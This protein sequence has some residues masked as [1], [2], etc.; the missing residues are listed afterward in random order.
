MNKEM[1]VREVADVLNVTPEAIKEWIRELYPDK[2]KNGVVTF[3]DEVEVTA[4]KLKMRPTTFV[5]GAKTDL[6]KKLIINQAMGFLQEEITTLQSQNLQ[7]QSTV[8]LLT[9]DTSKTFTAGE[10]AKEIG[11][12]SA[13]AL[14]LKLHEH[15]IIYKHN[16]T[17]LPYSE[18]ADKGY[19][20]IKQEEVNGIIIYH[21]RWT[22]EGRLFILNLFSKERGIQ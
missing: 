9:H 13:F 5:V 10:I 7:L 17:W 1:S 14:N 3:L 2:L 18:Y 16:N 6:E 11:F 19:M 20:E 15:H 4:I 22:P 12:K 21:A 8:Q